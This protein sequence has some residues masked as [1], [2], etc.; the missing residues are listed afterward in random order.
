MRVFYVRPSDNGNYC[1]EPAL[2][3]LTH[4][5]EQVDV[6]LFRGRR[7]PLEPLNYDP[8]D[9]GFA[10]LNAYDIAILA[11]LDPV[12]LSPQECLALIAFVE[13]GGGLMVLGGTHSF[14]NAEGT[15]LP[16]AVMLPVE[17]QRGLD[18]EVNALPHPTGHPIARGL[19]EPLGYISK[20]HPVA[21]KP[22]GETVLTVG[23]QP[24]AVA[25]EYGY[26][27]VVVLASYPECEE[28]EYGWFFTGDAFDDFMRRAVAWMRKQQDPAWI[29]AFVLP[30]REVTT[31]SDQ[32][33]KVLLKAVAPTDVRLVTRLTR[34]GETV[35]EDSTRSRVATAHEA[36]FSFRVPGGAEAD[37]L[38]YVSATLF[39]LEGRELDRS[40]AGLVVVNPT[41]L[42][43]ELEYGRR[44]LVP[45][46]TVRIR[47]N[48]FSERRVPPL[49][50]SVGLAL[51]DADGAAAVEM[52]EVTLSWAGSGYEQ[53]EYEL[54]V[55]HLRPGAY[56][57]RAELRFAG[58]LADAAE[59]EISVLPRLDDVRR[60]PLISEGGY[61]L[62]RAAI[63][64]GVAALAQAGA[65]TLSLPGPVATA[66][67]ERQHWEAMLGYA[68]EQALRSGLAL[69]HHRHSLVPG[70]TTRAPL[71]PCPL[72]P[73]LGEALDAQIRPVLAAAS[74]VPRLLFH[75]ILPETAVRWE[76]LCRC[77]AC[78]AAYE[79]NFGGAL[80]VEAPEALEPQDLHGL[81][82][83]VSSYWWHVY[84]VLS[85]LRDE[86][87]EG[88]RLSLP[89]GAESFLR[90]GRAAPYC[91][92][93]SWVRAAEV[94]E[95]APEPDAA[96]YR[97]SL[98]GHRALCQAFGKPF[99]ALIDLAAGALPPAEAAFTA[100]AHGAEH[101]R[102]A[103]NPR[104]LHGRRQPP[105][106]EALGRLFA[107][108]AKA[109]PLLALSHRPQAR[110]ALLY[111]F[112]Q[113]VDRDSRGLL[114][115]FELLTAAFGDVDLVHQRLARDTSIQAYGAVA[116]LGTR[117]L[118]KKVARELVA[119]VEQ[120]GIL[121]A[122]SAEVLDE[123]GRL[124]VW[125]DRFFGTAETPV[126]ETVTE[127][128]RAYR[129]GRTTLFSP[130]I[131]GIYR[132]TLERCD[133]LAARGITRAM[134]DALAERGVRPRASAGHPDVE[135]GLREC[136]GARLLVAVN[137]GDEAVTTRVE[138]DGEVTCA[139]DLT[140][141]EDVPVRGSAVE[142]SL[143][144]RDGGVWVLYGQRSF[145]VRLELAEAQAPPGGEIAGRAAV[146]NEAGQPVAASHIVRVFVTDPDGAERADLGGER[147]TADGVL[148]LRLPLAVN[149]RL[150]TWAISVTDVLTRRIVRRTFEVVAE[151]PP[152]D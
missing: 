127:R 33:G 58:G 12:V 20:L 85:G 14:G 96:T 56:R 67:G 86:A 39:D 134:A 98:S 42:S 82:A 30:A 123:R 128:R 29:D 124:L 114:D 75:E 109:G 77:K 101:L 11:G 139:F 37:G 120:G 31:G 150:G 72:T 143:P 78:Q 152:E 105:L 40:E 100:L 89:F 48:A 46:E 22:G 21:V 54:D 93:H 88:V 8:T 79:R 138:L 113:V 53:A 117:M 141:G 112:T 60:F 147:V 84:S 44:C 61:H 102:V 73:A 90:P 57:L 17:M 36:I 151:A 6:A 16:L 63:E 65:N 99:G 81:C 3:T 59:E 126:F 87:G 51:L 148:E 1:V 110:V 80:P 144:P 91:D 38:H 125:P 10:D 115:A 47:V 94:V 41:R 132:R 107:R 116:I 130:D 137:H 66:W 133:V 118:P 35:H 121:L 19:P 5:P 149:E 119:F 83:F 43:L 76:Q 9:G 136:P 26:G 62:D 7:V 49:Q 25:G 32:F 122:D 23:E 104:F 111:P 55:P 97:L 69:A 2:A 68:E 95:V 131:A 15:W 52:D 74:R 64:R 92:V 70:L 50:V 45:G 140:T 103:E 142:V 13:R 108:I 106:G 27:R 28:A 4:P 34:D 129:G 135:V 18:V 146:V 24:L 145:S 71:D